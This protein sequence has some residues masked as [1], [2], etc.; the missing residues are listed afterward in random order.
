MSNNTRFPYIPKQTIFHERI[1]HPELYNDHN[2]RLE[3]VIGEMKEIIYDA[4]AMKNIILGEVQK[5][6]E[7]NDK[8]NYSVHNRIDEIMNKLNT[9]ESAQTDKF[10]IINKL[11]TKINDQLTKFDLEPEFDIEPE[12]VIKPDSSIN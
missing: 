10:N 12:P 8:N 4:V 1:S 6:S 3:R 5:W 9:I 2:N 7:I 11:L